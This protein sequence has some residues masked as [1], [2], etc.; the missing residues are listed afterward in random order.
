MKIPQT[1]VLPAKYSCKQYVDRAS[2][3]S[4]F[5]DQASSSA[6]PLRLLPARGFLSSLCILPF[7]FEVQYRMISNTAKHFRSIQTAMETS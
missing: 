2:V 4:V 6:R 1:K 3:I 7:V 5:L